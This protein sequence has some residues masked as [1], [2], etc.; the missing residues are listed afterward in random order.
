MYDLP[1]PNVVTVIKIGDFTLRAYAYRKL[2][3]SECKFA[4]RQYL[5]KFKLKSIPKSG[6]GKIITIIGSIQ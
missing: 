5:R 4:L 1:T 2:T 3:E 6:S